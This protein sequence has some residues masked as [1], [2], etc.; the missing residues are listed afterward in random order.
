[1][2]EEKDFHLPYDLGMRLHENKP[3]F[4]SPMANGFS[5]GFSGSGGLTGLCLLVVQPWV[6]KTRHRWSQPHQMVQESTKMTRGTHRNIEKLGEIRTSLLTARPALQKSQD[7]NGKDA[8]EGYLL[9]T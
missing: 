8:E 4:T 9:P 1:M 3:L 2:W 6:G 5:F 7:L